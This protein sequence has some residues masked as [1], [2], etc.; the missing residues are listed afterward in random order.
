M[1]RAK[2][3]FAMVIASVFLLGAAP[4]AAFSQDKNA[5]RK[6][7][8]VP[9]ALVDCKEDMDCFIRAAQTCRR[10]TVTRTS[11]LSVFGITITPTWF[12]ETRNKRAGQCTVYMRTE[13]VEAKINEATKR[14]LLAN[15]MTPAEFEEMSAEAEK[16][17]HG[18][19]GADGICVFKANDYL[20][21]LKRW[22]A[23]TYSTEDWKLGRCKG[24]MFPEIRI[25]INVHSRILTGRK[26]TMAYNVDLSQRRA[27]AIV[28]RLVSR[29]GIAQTRLTPQGLGFKSPIA[30]N[31]TEEGRAKNRRVELVEQ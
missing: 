4:L 30:T 6:P 5:L 17:A 24:R 1:T 26:G 15:G 11:S 2:H 14:S 19:E 7:T 16:H 23:G 27:D 22:N 13:K 25:K 31:K 28:N 12:I 18:G 3:A 8:G 29:Y 10:A 20:A 21:L 9:S